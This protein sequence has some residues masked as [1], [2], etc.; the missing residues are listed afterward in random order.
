MRHK[1]NFQ[2]FANRSDFQT[3]TISVTRLPNKVILTIGTGFPSLSFDLIEAKAIE[4]KTEIQR[5]LFRLADRV[6]EL[7]DQLKGKN[8]WRN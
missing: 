8:S 5:I 4:N 7:T 1:T 2:L 3:G 6:L